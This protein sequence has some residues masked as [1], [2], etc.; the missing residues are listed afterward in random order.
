M[1][2]LGKNYIGITTCL[3]STC[4]RLTFAVSFLE[5]RRLHQLEITPTDT[6]DL[7]TG[8][9]RLMKSTYSYSLP[10]GC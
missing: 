8:L 3:K 1:T 2:S 5:T 6:E 10:L 9:T 7:E 4:Y